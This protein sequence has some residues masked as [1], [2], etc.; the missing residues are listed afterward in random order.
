MKKKFLPKYQPARLVSGNPRWYILWYAPFGKDPLYRFRQTFLLNRI[1]DLA[2]RRLRGEVLV[3]K[4]NWWLEQGLPSEKFDEDTIPLLMASTIQMKKQIPQ[5]AQQPAISRPS[6]WDTPTKDALIQARRLKCTS[7][8]KD[9]NTAYSSIIRLLER[10]MEQKGWEQMP[11]GNFTKEHAGEYLDH[12]RLE[13]NVNNNTYNNNLIQAKMVFKVLVTRGYLEQNP[14]DGFHSLPKLK[15]QRRNFSDKEASIVAAEIA[16]CDRLLFY[17]L[18]LQYTCFVRPSELRRLK[19]KDIDTVKGL[20]F[21]AEEHEK[22]RREKTCTIPNDFLLFF[23]EPFWEKYPRH[24][25]LFGEGWAPNEKRQC[26]ER[27]MNRRHRLVLKNLLKQKKL[28]DITGLSW[29]SWKD[30]GITDAIY[31]LHPSAVQDQANHADI[32]M[33]LRYRHRRPV[34]EPMRSF[35]NKI[36]RNEEL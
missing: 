9:T 34:N 6:K 5:I 24:W 11:V 13:R 3:E 19:F 22:T 21:V 36:I 20:V 32:Q 10:F 31:E 14:F 33:T 18:L 26:G 16:E 35:K 30:T 12:C 2:L 8:R 25:F 1:K 28:D 27:E 4:I 7:D 15:K 29:Y 23:R 17:G